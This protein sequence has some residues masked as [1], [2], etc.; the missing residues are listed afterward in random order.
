VPGCSFF[1]YGTKQWGVNV[2][3]GDIDGDG[4]DEIV[5]SPGPGIVFG[6]AI[7]GFEYTGSSTQAMSHVNFFAYDQSQFK[8]GAY[9]AVGN[10]DAAGNHEILTAPGAGVGYTAHIRVWDVNGSV[11][12]REEFQAFGAT[13]DTYG[14]RVSTTK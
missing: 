6:P 9:A 14:A 4:K 5:T 13:Q 12:M 7:R 3:A 11:T 8:Y 10:V 2:A 1:A